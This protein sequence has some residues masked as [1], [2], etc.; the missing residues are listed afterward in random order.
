MRAQVWPDGDY[1]GIKVIFHN[2]QD[3][4]GA[5]WVVKKYLTEATFLPGMKTVY[6]P[7][8]HGDEPPGDEEILNHIVIMLD[9]T[10][11]RE[12]MLRIHGMGFLIVLDHHKSVLSMALEEIDCLRVILDK[13]ACMITWEYFFPG[14]EAPLFLC[15]MEDFDLWRFDLPDSEIL[16]FY[17]H[18]FPLNFNTMDRLCIHF[19]D[20]YYLKQAKNEGKAIKRYIDRMIQWSVDESGEMIIDGKII[21]AANTHYFIGS[22]VAHRLSADVDF[23]IAYRIAGDFLKVSLRSEENG[24]DVSM[25]A[26]KYGGGGHKH[27]A[28]FAVKIP[29][30]IQSLLEL[31]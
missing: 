18:S 8:Q 3:G 20:N 13:A 31:E 11:D 14:E 22:K 7:Y 5:A 21:K 16:N 6:M 4:W 29:G 23:S 27:A 12:T 19:G 1:E 24:S 25:V 10:F 2:D 26:Q 15:Y 17:I 28:G 30:V 9:F